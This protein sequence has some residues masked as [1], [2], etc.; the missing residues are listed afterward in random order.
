MRIIILILLI[1]FG[2]FTQAQPMSM[3]LLKNSTI[4]SQNFTLY[5]EQI[6]AAGTTGNP[7]SPFNSEIITANQA[8][9]LTGG[10]TM[11]LVNTNGATMRLYQIYTVTASTLYY[12]SW[13]IKRGTK[14]D[15]Q[16]NVYDVTHGSFIISPVSYYSSTSSTVQRFNTS[17]TTPSGCT[18]IQISYVDDGADFTTGTFYLGRVQLNTRLNAPYIVTTSSTIP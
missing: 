16:Y 3:L 4:A 13:D 2:I 14:T 1:F 11:E 10:T 17:F 8:A 15:L 18:S 6:D 5:S 9:D 7:W 12:A